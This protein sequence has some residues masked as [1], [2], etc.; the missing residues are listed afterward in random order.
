MI[1]EGVI[2]TIDDEFGGTPAP[3]GQTLYFDKTVPPHYLYVICQAQLV[4]GK[5]SNP[6]VM[7][8]SGLYRDSDPVLSPDGSTM[9]FASDRPVNGVEQKR[10]LIWETK[11]KGSIWSEPAL[12]GGAINSEGSQVFASTTN[13][14]TMYFTSSRK[15]GQ[16][17]IYRSRLF[18]GRYEVSEDLGPLVNVPGVWSL[19]AWVAPD[20]SYLLIGSFGREGFGNSDLYVSFRENGNWGKPINL[21]S[22]INTAAREYSARVSA[23]GQWLY[24]SSEWGMPYE[25]R[26]QPL[27]YQQYENGMKSVKNGLGNLYRVPLAPVLAAARLKGRSPG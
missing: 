12:T 19:E 24:Y 1:G 3:D 27:T 16:Y 10:F 6:Q 26:T 22:E 9:Y 2:S 13:N 17:D 25:K 15:N 14:G 5:W 8:F 23:D 18:D 4:N 11:K 20:E 21:G 7:P